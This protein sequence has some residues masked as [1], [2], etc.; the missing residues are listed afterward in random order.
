M[1]PLELGHYHHSRYLDMIEDRREVEE[2]WQEISEKVLPRKSYVTE[3][4]DGFADNAKFRRLVDTTAVDACQ[5]LANGHSSYITPADQR[6]FYWSAPERVKTDE[7]EGWYRHCSTLAAMEISSSNFYTNLDEAYLDRSG[8]GIATFSAWPSRAGGLNVQ[9][10]P[11]NSYTIEESEEGYVDTI[12][13]L[14][15]KGI[16]QLVLLLGEDNIQKSEKLA[17]SWK[18][19]KMKGRNK[20]HRVLHCVYPR[21]MEGATSTALVLRGVRCRS[22]TSSTS[23][24]RCETSSQKSRQFRQSFTR[25]TWKATSTFVAVVPPRS[26]QERLPGRITFLMSGAT[27]VAM[28]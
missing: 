13:F 21:E 1:I 15:E 23:S 20:K 26:R 25:T 18:E 17:T 2:W 27:K 24:A 9:V 3:A 5:T 14:I 4:N 19:Y 16:R 6:W 12:Y 22:L 10:H 8:F 11:V 7:V 28:T